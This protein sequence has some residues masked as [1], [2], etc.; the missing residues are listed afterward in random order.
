MH[1]IGFTRGWIHSSNLL[2]FKPIA[3]LNSQKYGSEQMWMSKTAQADS[4]DGGSASKTT[5]SIECR[6]TNRL[7][8]VRVCRGL[9]DLF[10]RVIPSH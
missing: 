10:S 4:Y 9:K 6:P 8:T 2:F 7:L 1:K 3:E 5:P